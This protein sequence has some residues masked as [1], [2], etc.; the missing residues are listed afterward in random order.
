MNNANSTTQ[1]WDPPRSLKTTTAVPDSL[2]I[3]DLPEIA[4]PHLL[5]IA[6]NLQCPLEYAA[7]PF[8]V[9]FSALIGRRVAIR[10]H[11]HDL[12]VMVPN[13]WGAVVSPPGS[14]HGAAARLAIAPLE[15]LQSRAIIKYRQKCRDYAEGKG[16]PPKLRGPVPKCRRFVLTDVTTER[17][18]EI[19]RENP[20][21]FLLRRDDLTDWFRSVACDAKRTAAAL[22]LQAWHGDR[23]FISDRIRRGMIDVRSACLSIFGGLNPQA[24]QSI[25]S[26]NGAI[27]SATAN[28]LP[29]FQILFWPDDAHAWKPSDPPAPLGSAATDLLSGLFTQIVEG[30]AIPGDLPRDKKSDVPFV[31]LTPAAR[32]Q[33]LDWRAELESSL[34]GD[35]LS[36]L[37]HA[38]RVRYRSLVPSLAL[39]FRT[40]DGPPSEV[41]EKH[42]ALAIR[43]EKIL[44]SH[45]RRVYGALAMPAH[46]SAA[47]R[48]IRRLLLDPAR[49]HKFTL[50]ELRRCQWSDLADPKI[51]DEALD[52]LLDS[53]HIRPCKQTFHRR[54]IRYELNPLTEASEV[55]AHQ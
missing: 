32:Q 33:Y 45:A 50:R 26:K 23:S 41:D 39:L 31:L 22:Y 34:Q 9:A 40:L 24:L 48:L 17:L 52:T 8:I 5:N 38:H 29:H 27:A 37:L 18:I 30:V 15:E 42:L 54:V 53:G 1:A 55:S 51:L 49:W 44:W 11:Q 43:W 20:M 35:D 14:M 25:F 7:A 21:G 13:L 6:S 19:M 36:P 3:E 46:D 4:R 47:R 10:I 28:F 2:Q 16:L 12:C